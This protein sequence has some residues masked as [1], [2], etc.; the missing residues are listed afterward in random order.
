[1]PPGVGPEGIAY[2]SVPALSGRR[3]A[4]HVRMHRA[5][6]VHR[7]AGCS[8][9]WHSH[10]D[11]NHK[12]LYWDT[13]SGDAFRLWYG[14]TGEITALRKWDGILPRYAAMCATPGLLP[15]FEELLAELKTIPELID[16]RGSEIELLQISD[17]IPPPGQR[18]EVMAPRKRAN[19]EDHWQR[20]C[21]RGEHNSHCPPATCPVKVA[22]A[23]SRKPRRQPVA[24]SVA[25][26]EAE[27]EAGRQPVSSGTGR[28]GQGGRTTPTPRAS[29]PSQAGPPPSPPGVVDLLTGEVDVCADCDEALTW[30]K[31]G[32]RVN[33][34]T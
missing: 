6:L 20:K 21:A 17:F 31:C 30:C 10:D 23:E 32:T 16:D 29:V 7:S 15:R 2:P 27:V 22:K 18:P 11:Q 9:S 24:D 14:L 13:V 3:V 28:G 19:L 4:S 12:Q 8:M 25:D 34:P 5:H 26:P 1:M 33:D